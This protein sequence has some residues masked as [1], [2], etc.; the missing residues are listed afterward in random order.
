MK[1]TIKRIPLARQVY[2]YFK[3]KEYEQKFATNAYGCFWGVF[4]TFDQARQAS[5]QTKIKSH[6][7]QPS[8]S[9]SSRDI[10]N[11]GAG[12]KHDAQYLS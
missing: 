1:N 12:S 10:G 8:R 7:S 5:P 11:N 2:R 6:A 9:I 4:E 3:E